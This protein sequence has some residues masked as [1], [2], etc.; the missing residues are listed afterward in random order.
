MPLDH[1]P[2]G[3]HGWKGLND[4][5]VPMVTDQKG[6]LPMEDENVLDSDRLPEKK[7]VDNAVRSKLIKCKPVNSTLNNVTMEISLTSLLVQ[8][9]NVKVRGDFVNGAFSRSINPDLLPLIDQVKCHLIPRWQAG[10]LEGNRVRSEQAANH[11][12]KLCTYSVDTFKTSEK[13]AECLA[14]NEWM[15]TFEAIADDRYW[16]QVVPSE[17]CIH[18]YEDSDV[19][20]EQS[21]IHDRS[22]KNDQSVS[23]SEKSVVL[24]QK[25]KSRK[26]KVEELVISS[27]DDSSVLAVSSTEYSSASTDVS[28]SSRS[29]RRKRRNR[30]KDSKVVVKPPMFQMDGS[31]SLE[32]FLETYEKYF[33]NKYN[34]NAYDMTQMLAKFLSGDILKVYEIRGGRKMKYNKMK[35]ELTQYYKQQKIGGRTY[36]RKQLQSVTLENG[37]TY[38]ILGMRLAE[39]AKKAYPKDK[40]ECATHLR[41]QFLR[42]LPT[43]FVLKVSDAERANNA[44]NRNKKH[45]PFSSIVQIAKDLQS[46]S[47]KPR[48]IMWSTETWKSPAETPETS[49]NN[50]PVTEERRTTRQFGK[51]FYPANH[52]QLKCSYCHRSGHKVADCWRASNRCLICGGQHIL[53][54]CSR[55]D[56][57]HRSRSQNRPNT[58]QSHLN[59]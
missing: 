57:R 47:V 9:A 52:E 45:L 24:K 41:Q 14:Y 49:R 37:E 4:E 12:V 44:V 38:E 3:G 17:R 53:E 58:S 2:P 15:R 16:H 29:R 48:T 7:E 59:E 11:F 34:G 55:Y 50:R 28:E 6:D 26:S 40:K 1:S 39:I 43:E 42:C 51:N 20:V 22:S 33:K 21:S 19:K 30:Y 56:P 54:K 18:T 8:F 10:G 5:A 27:S 13:P 36:W 46:V 25:D 32:D 35:S 31:S 23:S